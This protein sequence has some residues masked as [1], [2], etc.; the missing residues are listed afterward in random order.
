MN[1]PS[2][3]SIEKEESILGEDKPMFISIL[4]GL[5]VILNIIFAIIVIFL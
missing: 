2:L 1:F 3:V 5:V 4:F